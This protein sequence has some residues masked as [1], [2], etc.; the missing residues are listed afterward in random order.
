MTERNVQSHLV[1]LSERTVDW[2]LTSG[3]SV[4]VVLAL[5]YGAVRLYRLVIRPFPTANV[6]KSAPV[7][8]AIATK[9]SPAKIPLAK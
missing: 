9:N 6:F 1:T 3:I 5:T 4:L 8:P 2:L 7:I